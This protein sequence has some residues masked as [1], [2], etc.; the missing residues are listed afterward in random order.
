MTGEGLMVFLLPERS[1]SG[2][3]KSTYSSGFLFIFKGSQGCPLIMYLDNVGL[4]VMVYSVEV[5][6]PFTGIVP[7]PTSA[8]SQAEALR[9]GCH[10][11]KCF[12][13]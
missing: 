5:L 11:L 1:P 3:I 12:G 7:H 13:V 10:A 9:V 4:H 2:Q 8:F 6:D